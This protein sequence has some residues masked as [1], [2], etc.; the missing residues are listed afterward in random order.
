MSSCNKYVVIC[1][2]EAQTV[3]S[4][5]TDWMTSVQSLAEAKDFS[6]APLS[7]PDLRP[8][9]PP[10][11]W[12][13]GVRRIWGVT[14]TTHLHLVLR[15]RMS[16]YSIPSSPWCLHGIARQLYFYILFILNVGI[17]IMTFRILGLY[18]ENINCK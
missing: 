9:Q 11:Q 18:Y 16:R 8:T 12:V 6:L 1:I 13:L 2:R 4:V 10:I 3:W 17:D 7:R 15:S 5:T 14:L